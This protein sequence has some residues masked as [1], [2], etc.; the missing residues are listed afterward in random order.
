M[1]ETNEQRMERIATEE[2]AIAGIERAVERFRSG[3]ASYKAVIKEIEN[4]TE[5]RIVRVGATTHTPEV[6]T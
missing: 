5:P 3:E 6:Q 4:A 1:S 2:A